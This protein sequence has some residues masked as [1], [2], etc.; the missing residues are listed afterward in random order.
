MNGP[1][2]GTREHARL[3]TASKAAAILGISPWESP[4]SLWHLMA[5][6]TD[7]TPSNR[8]QRRGQ[9]LEPAIL[10]WWR[11]Q[12]PEH[13]AYRE[14]VWTAFEDWAGCTTDAECDLDGLHTVVEAKSAVSFDDW[15][16][17]GTD[18][19]PDYYLAQVLFQLAVTGAGQCRVAVF[20]G[21]LEFREY[22]VDADPGE[23]ARLLGAC[24]RFYDSLAG[25]VPPELDRSVATY[26]SVRSLHPGIDGT[27]VVVDVVT[28]GSYVDA[29]AAAADAAEAE[30][31]AKSVLLDA[32]G[33]ARRAV[34]GDVVVA[35]RQPNG[36]GVSL[37]RVADKL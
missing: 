4:Y 19:I 8:A 5:G 21:R 32:M 29:V 31:F 26:D 27:D 14:Q 24:R 22:V 1:K 20:G 2:P 10:A 33:D 35:R 17:P 9:Y 28:A 37:V 7:P 16:T 6:N 18:Q 3:V 34:C 12:H 13:A 15:G 11:D 23:Q 36:R 30:R 25:G